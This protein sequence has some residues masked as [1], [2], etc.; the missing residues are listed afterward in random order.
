MIRVS[1]LI[2]TI[3]MFMLV[4]VILSLVITA[5]PPGPVDGKV[6]N[7]VKQYQGDN[8]PYEVLNVTT[9]KGIVQVT[10]SCDYY[11]E[12]S[13]IQVY[14]SVSGFWLWPFGS[15][16]RG[17]QLGQVQAGCSKS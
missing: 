3:T 10:V 2:Y 7:V 4:W 8:A 9:P 14:P 13:Q 5:S 16:T 1:Y 12:G 6:T 11:V 15:F 17:S